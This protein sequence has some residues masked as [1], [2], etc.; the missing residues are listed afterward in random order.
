MKK[1]LLVFAYFIALFLFSKIAWWS[2][3]D[4]ILPN[5][6]LTMVLFLLSIVSVFLLVG[7]GI[8]YVTTEAFFFIKYI[9]KRIWERK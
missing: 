3:F 4:A 1:L 2:F 6:Y 5:P 8:G 7:F 9:I